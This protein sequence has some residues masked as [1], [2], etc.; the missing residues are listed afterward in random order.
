MQH[1]T[2]SLANGLRVVSVPLPHLHSVELAVYCKVGARNDP[3]G[4]TGLSHFLEHMLFRGTTDYPSSLEIETAFEELGGSV[5]AA[6]DADSTCFYARIHPDHAAQGLAIL[7][8]MLLRPTLQGVDLE[9]RIIGEEALE[10]LNEEGVLT[11]PDLVMGQLLWPGHPLG[12]AT[13]GSL[14]DIERIS[15][16]DLRHHLATW[17]RPSNAVVVVAGPHDPA[18]MLATAQTCFGAWQPAP[19]PLVLRV[20]PQPKDSRRNAFV[21]DADSQITLQLAFPAFQR[22]DPR[23]T[24]LKVLRRLLA[25]G[26]C[27]RLH[28]K[29]REELGLVYAVESAI[30]AYDETGCIT[31]DCATAPENLAAVI[32]AILV[33]LRQVSENPIPP[34]E[35][36]RVR[37]A[38]LADLDY[39]RDSVTEMGARYGWGTLMGV[40]RSIDDDQQLVRQVTADQLRGLAQQLF[41]PD[42]RFLAAIGP[43]EG[44]D[45]T[46]IERLVQG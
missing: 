26:G 23:M 39:S 32:A 46:A 1:Q 27:S 16:A 2:S 25:G 33:E 31:I 5:N 35:L 11:N 14:E 10:D 28:L 24:G 38:Y 6:T 29:L 37:T 3:P 12:G 42:N 30:G 43:L 40:V 34:Q 15:E 13:V 21:T 8:S 17:Y 44:V 19:T 9:R 4:R 45:R 20:G 18:A 41:R 7:A 36:E 22:D